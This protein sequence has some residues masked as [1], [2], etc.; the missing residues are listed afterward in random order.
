MKYDRVMTMANGKMIEFESP[1]SLMKQEDSYFAHLVNQSYKWDEDS[2]VTDLSTTFVTF[3]C[4]T[5][6][7]RKSYIHEVHLFHL[8]MQYGTCCVTVAWYFSLVHY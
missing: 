3:R 2:Q 4:K 7:N 1:Q 6:H 8:K 5:I